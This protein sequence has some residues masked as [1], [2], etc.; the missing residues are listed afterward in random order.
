MKKLLLFSLALCFTS[1]GWSQVGLLP[2]YPNNWDCYYLISADEPTDTNWKTKS[3]PSGFTAGT[4]SF[5]TTS[6][7]PRKYST[8]WTDCDTN[9]LYV[10]R[11]LSLTQSQLDDMLDD[12]TLYF[13]EDQDAVFYLNGEQIGIKDNGRSIGEGDTGSSPTSWRSFTIS[14]D[15]LKVGDNIFAVFVNHGAYAQFLDFGVYATL[16]SSAYQLPTL[17][18]GGMYRAQF[19]CSDTEPSSGWNNVG[20]T[21][22][23]FTSSFGPYSGGWTNEGWILWD[24]AND[25]KDLYVRRTFNI[26]SEELKKFK[27]GIATLSL[28]Y[29]EKPI[30]YLN[31]HEIFNDPGGIGITN[32]G[33]C[34]SITDYKTKILTAEEM[35]YL[36]EGDN[37]LAVKAKSGIGGQYLDYGLQLSLQGYVSKL[38]DGYYYIVAGFDEVALTTTLTNGTYYLAKSK[39]TSNAGADNFDEPT[40]A[41]KLDLSQVFHILKTGDN[42]YTIQNMATNYYVGEYN[43]SGTGNE[44]AF[45]A[46]ETSPYN[47]SIYKLSESPVSEDVAQDNAD[48][49]TKDNA[50]GAFDANN[51]E[52]AGDWNS[53]YIHV[54]A[55]D[56]RA[57]AIKFYNVTYLYNEYNKNK[58]LNELLSSAQTSLKT[59]TPANHHDN[60]G[61]K[62]FLLGD[63]KTSVDGLATSKTAIAALQAAYDAV[64]AGYYT[65]GKTIDELSNE[66]QA[67]K[68]AQAIVDKKSNPLTDG[69]Y[70]IIAEYGDDTNNVPGGFALT[71]NGVSN[72]R[73][74]LSKTAYNE[75]DANQI[76]KVNYDADNGKI[77]LQNATT[78]LYI[79]TVSNDK[80]ELTATETQLN[81][82][83]GKD[84]YWHWGSPKNDAARSCSFLIYDDNNNG[85][86]T[87]TA[88][89]SQTET[90]AL[91]ETGSDEA[92]RTDAWFLS[93]AFRPV[94]DVIAATLENGEFPGSLAENKIITISNSELTGT[95]VNNDDVISDLVLTDK[96]NFEP[97]QNFAATAQTATYTRHMNSGTNWGTIILPFNVSVTDDADVAFYQVESK[98]E[99]GALN[100]VKTNTLHIGTP[101]LFKTNKE[102]F[103]LT[104]TNATIM[105]DINQNTEGGVTLIGTYKRDTVDVDNTYFIKD[106]KF[107]SKGDYSF[108]VSPFRAYLQDPSGKSNGFSIVVDD[109]PTGINGAATGEA[110]NEIE[111]VYSVGGVKQSTLQKGINIIKYRNGK[112]QKVI[113]K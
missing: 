73:A 56:A 3:A 27:N 35:S 64:Y 36:Q 53:T 8:E 12:V 70:Y 38:S 110:G 10:V 91:K 2:I 66:I 57:H 87:S 62:S 90:Q 6:Y 107:Y 60:G 102:S 104:A 54:K 22:S 9:D 49:F 105:S 100:V 7:S 50:F 25:G 82:V 108:I 19:L 1:I 21:G 52:W 84:Y 31:G 69:Y 59:N 4:G 44:L 18:E 83:S 80:W 37:V 88:K 5:S 45:K 75:T 94:S 106:N 61:T 112:T 81:V 77:R 86:K 58:E 42:T 16:K 74:A 30:V 17:A 20:Y 97:G 46:S 43:S 24:G 95:N 78:G 93:W 67:L 111:S 28:T 109:D 55:T 92:T 89:N 32:E 63:E 23:D 71:Y 101:A 65:D 47:Y 48:H 40:S 113:L 68:D 79:G 26:S 13:I 98:S 103:T 15:K 33:W 96:V 39:A 76:F 51:N 29:D 14:K 11:T 99:D 34:S 72:N 85:M 41:D